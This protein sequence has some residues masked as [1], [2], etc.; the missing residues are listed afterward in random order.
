LSSNSFPSSFESDTA[1]IA[2]P[3]AGALDSFERS[4]SGDVLLSAMKDVFDGEFK[5]E[6][7]VQTNRNVIPSSVHDFDVADSTDQASGEELL[8]KALGAQIISKEEQ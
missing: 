7:I 8:M 1:R 3:S 4:N 2:L 5:V 6:M